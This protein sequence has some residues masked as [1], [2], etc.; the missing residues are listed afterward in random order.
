MGTSP[1]VQG[2]GAT[3]RD[4][5]ADKS[6]A[7]PWHIRCDAGAAMNAFPESIHDPVALPGRSAG[8]HTAVCDFKR[9]LIEATLL[10][11]RGNR[12]H[13]ARALGLQRTYLLRLIR[14]LGVAAPPPPI[15]RRS[16]AG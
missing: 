4:G 13:T 15:R 14:E 3:T 11:M 6:R 2:T 5:V 10:Q 12:T 1:R 9:R 16:L 7:R 8:Y